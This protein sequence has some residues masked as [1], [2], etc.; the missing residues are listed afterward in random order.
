MD[1]G[2]GIVVGTIH[3]VQ[4]GQK[5]RFWHHL[6]WQRSVTFANNCKLH[7]TCLKTITM[8]RW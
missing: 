6:S 5:R 8:A 7:A 2:H 4:Y 1:L 3:A